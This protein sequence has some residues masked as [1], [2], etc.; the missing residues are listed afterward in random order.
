MPGDYTKEETDA[1]LARAVELH[2]SE[3]TTHEELVA[4]A[5]EVGVS[6]DAVD[7]AAAE[8]LGGR[9]DREALA[10]QRARAWR[11]FLAHLVPYVMV[12][13]L[14]GFINYVTTSFPWALIVM[15]AWGV[16]LASHL[17]AVVLPDPEEQLRRIELDRRRAE[18]RAVR[19]N[20]EEPRL[21]LPPPGHAGDVEE[22]E[23]PA[24]SDA[25]VHADCQR[26]DGSPHEGS[27]H[28]RGGH[29]VARGVRSHLRRF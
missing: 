10:A 8:V 20:T 11:H 17:L 5:G 2:R 27:A 9:R 4:A 24:E 13:A 16:G 3:R 26:C 23:E 29:P 6:R 1:I 22:D 12:S 25:L 14:L 19:V 28:E 18:G 15:L 21:R 7:K